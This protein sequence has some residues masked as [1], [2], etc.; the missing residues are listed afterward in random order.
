MNLSRLKFMHTFQNNFQKVILGRR[1]D[2]ALLPQIDSYVKKR[3][4]GLWDELVAVK[5]K[6]EV[7]EDSTSG[8]C[9]LYKRPTTDLQVVRQ[10]EP[11]YA[12]DSIG[13]EIRASGCILRS[14]R[15]VLL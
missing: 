15:P 3:T 5:K 9:G 8:S 7:I 6:L 11:N 13:K 10:E 2:E 14:I 12:L 4:Q 1:P